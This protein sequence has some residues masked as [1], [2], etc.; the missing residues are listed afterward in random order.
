MSCCFFHHHLRMLKY[1]TF[2]I[3]K[4]PL[5]LS[6]KRDSEVDCFLLPSPRPAAHTSTRLYIPSVKRQNWISSGCRTGSSEG[7]STQFAAEPFPGQLLYNPQ[8]QPLTWNSILQLCTHAIFLELFA[9]NNKC[10]QPSGYVDSWTVSICL[11][12][13]TLLT[14]LAKPPPDISGLWGWIWT[15]ERSS[16]PI[17]CYTSSEPHSLCRTE[18]LFK[19]RWL[20]KNSA[21][22][23]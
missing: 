14:E 23:G 16:C 11:V 19:H 12:L 22:H 17:S 10:Y 1:K 21:D 6:P 7:S 9:A 5:A 20:R 3:S 8:P 13:P 2:S 15:P 18:R 4:T